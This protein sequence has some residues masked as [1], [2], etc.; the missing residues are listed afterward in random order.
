[1]IDSGHMLDVLFGKANALWRRET[2]HEAMLLMTALYKAD[3]EARE[4]IS[5]AILAGPPQQFLKEEGDE[6]K[7]GHIFEM[8]AILESEHL[9]LLPEAE[10]KL[11]TIREQHPEWKPAKFP[12]L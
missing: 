12:G 6:E 9:P 7:D 11:A 2:Q 4:Q 3:A 10:R 8:L 5:S 1:M